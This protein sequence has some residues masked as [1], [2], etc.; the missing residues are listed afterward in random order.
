M[1][2]EEQKPAVFVGPSR[3]ARRVRERIEVRSFVNN[4]EEQ[5]E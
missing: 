3:P 4:E 5:N 2:E 1:S